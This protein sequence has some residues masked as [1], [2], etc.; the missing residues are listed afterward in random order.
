MEKMNHSISEKML[1]SSK[2]NNYL[3]SI[4]I[5]FFP[6]IIRDHETHMREM[7]KGGLQWFCTERKE[8]G[9][10]ILKLEARWVC[11]RRC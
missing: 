4:V 11:T 2:E 8:K 9:N 6:R 3:S 5:V 1:P 7:L 10:F